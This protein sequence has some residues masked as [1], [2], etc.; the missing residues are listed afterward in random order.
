[1]AAGGAIGK[2]IDLASDELSGRNSLRRGALRAMDKVTSKID[3]NALLER[4]MGK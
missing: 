4:M 1:V 2:G 3:V